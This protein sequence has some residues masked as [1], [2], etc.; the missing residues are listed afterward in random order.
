MLPEISIYTIIDTVKEGNPEADIDLILLAYEFAD[1]AHHGQKRLSGEPYIQ[2][3]LHTALR[4]AELNLDQATLV[5]ALL[6][7]V[8]EDTDRTI[9][10]VKKEFGGEIAHLVYGITKLGKIKYR[11]LER[12]A[13]NLRRMFVAMAEDIR[14]IFIKFADRIHNLKTLSVLP[15][16]KQQRIAQ[17]TLEIYAPIANRLGIQQLRG[18]M[19]DLAFPYVYPEEYEWVKN[20]VAEEYKKKT[21][22]LEKIKKDIARHM[23][24]SNIR[25]V[26]I[27][28]RAK[29]LYSLYRKLL[30]KN[31]DITKVFDLFAIRIIV[32]DIQDC[33]H[34]LGLLHSVFRPIPGRV[35]DYI[36]QPKPNQYR[37][38][39]TTVFTPYDMM[40][41][42]QIR[43]Q[44]MHEQAEYGIAAY[45]RYKEG[46]K[47][48][49][50]QIPE[51][52]MKW[53]R[54]LLELSRHRAGTQQYLD[55]LKLDIFSDRIFV[56]TPKG[57]VID[58]PENATPVDFAYHIHTEL[59]DHCGGAKVNDK[60]VS[61]NTKLHSGD[62]VEIIEDKNRKGP[63]EDWLKFVQSNMARQ[64]IKSYL[65]Q[66]HGKRLFPF[67]S[68]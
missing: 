65:K 45:W 42:F 52:Q 63:S 57:D 11:G 50:F 20:L 17:E 16:V 23:E 15:P 40:V 5:A 33:Y 7:D 38:L 46:G 14:V 28:S 8:P 29:H 2:H 59:G 4:I 12:Y 61:L 10:E 30:R 31:R 66:T 55:S 21:K 24:E 1:E 58:L 26:N 49:K 56:F 6:H 60:F 41:E 32:K 27:I 25:M 48:K 47:K 37:S 39:H 22:Y 67:F 19:E 44:E 53:I 18:E 68:R 35:K 34:M 51:A 43:T 36:A 9:E 54:E 64:K 62:I 3:S 13:E